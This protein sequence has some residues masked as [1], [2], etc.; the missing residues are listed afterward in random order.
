MQGTG[1]NSRVER[2]E[3]A[4]GKKGGPPQDEKPE[5]SSYQALL[6]T[7]AQSDLDE[8][9]Q[10]GSGLAAEVRS[11]PISMTTVVGDTPQTP[12]RTQMLLSASS[13]PTRFPLEPNWQGNLGN[14][15]CWLPAPESRALLGGTEG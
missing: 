8:N 15:A 7:W 6:G 5:A 1:H 12:V 13:S 11:H 3:E 9:R 14:R 2:A 10:S 4:K